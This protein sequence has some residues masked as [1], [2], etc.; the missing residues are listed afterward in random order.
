MW[1]AYTVKDG[2]RWIQVRPTAK[3]NDGNV[4][5]ATKEIAAH[6][7]AQVTQKVRTAG[8]EKIQKKGEQFLYYFNIYLS[9]MH[10]PW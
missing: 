3:D 6:V 5:R 7:T 2:M 1:Y 8:S 4:G 10:V 9:P